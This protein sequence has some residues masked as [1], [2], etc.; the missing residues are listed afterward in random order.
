M[1][2]IEGNYHTVVPLYF[3]LSLLLCP[4]ITTG[5]MLVV[6]VDRGGEFIIKLIAHNGTLEKNI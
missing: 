3:P 1:M 6:S 5:E 4:K 2:Q